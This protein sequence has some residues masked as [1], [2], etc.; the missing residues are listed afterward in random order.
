MVLQCGES[1]EVNQSAM[2]I[3]EISIYANESHQHP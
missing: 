3:T 1:A 2:Y